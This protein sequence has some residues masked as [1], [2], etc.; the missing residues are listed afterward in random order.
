MRY[1]WRPSL[2]LTRGLLNDQETNIV[3]MKYAF[4]IGSLFDPGKQTDF[5]GEYYE[6]SGG[7]HVAYY[8]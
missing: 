7:T 2:D 8:W 3:L 6:T 5:S 1:G 4:V